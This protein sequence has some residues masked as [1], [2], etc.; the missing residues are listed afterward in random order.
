MADF[1]FNVE[2]EQ[3]TE[4]LRIRLR[5]FASTR[6]YNSAIVFAC[7]ACWT[8]VKKNSAWITW[9]LPLGISPDKGPMIKSAYMVSA[10]MQG[11]EKVRT[12]KEVRRYET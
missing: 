9:T 5:C 4:S 1:Y 2:I 7:Q 11:G 8:G 10:N 6:R 3:T 12:A